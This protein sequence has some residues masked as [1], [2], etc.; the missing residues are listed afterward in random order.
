MSED[1]DDKFCF[2]CAKLKYLPDGVAKT[3]NAQDCRHLAKFNKQ[4]EEGVEVELHLGLRK[5][6][7]PVRGQA[8]RDLIQIRAS[9]QARNI[10]ITTLRH[11]T[12]LC[13]QINCQCLSKYGYLCNISNLH[14]FDSLA[15]GQYQPGN[16]SP[17][18]R[19]ANMSSMTSQHLQSVNSEE[20]GEYEEIQRDL[21]PLYTSEY[22]TMNS[23]SESTQ[24]SVR[25]VSRE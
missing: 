12:Q 17:M 24:S 7:M 10:C 25:S 11:L 8:R 15:M 21:R 4:L 5:I 19:S 16:N 20:M 14:S 2:V 18:V 1:I 22:R 23:Q 6:I 9:L 13:I 3:H